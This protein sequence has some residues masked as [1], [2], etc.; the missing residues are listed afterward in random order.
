MCAV[1]CDGIEECVSYPGYDE[2]ETNGCEDSCIK[3]FRA[4]P[5]KQTIQSPL[6]PENYAN[7]LDCEYDI[8]AFDGEVIEI[9]IETFHIENSGGCIYDVFA[10]QDGSKSP[11]QYLEVGGRKKVCGKVANDTIIESSESSVKI[12]FQT[13]FTVTKP[14]WSLTFKSK[15][16]TVQSRSKRSS[17]NSNASKSSLFDH[18][19]FDDYYYFYD[20]Y[21]SDELDQFD[22][23]TKYNWFGVYRKS[24]MPDYSDFRNF[25]SFKQTELIGNGH[26]KSDFIVQCVFDG[27]ICSP[28]EFSTIQT[29]T[30][31][32]CFTFN[33]V[34]NPEKNFTNHMRPLRTAKV[35]S[36]HGLKL[37]FFLDKEEYIGIIG[38]NSGARVTLF[39]SKEA[40]PVET[41]G[42]SLSAGTATI[43]ALK[44]ETIERKSDP[45]SSCATT[46]PDF[47]ELCDNYKK[48]QYTQDYC[49]HLCIMKSMISKCGCSDS[50][51]WDFSCNDKIKRLAATHCDV[52]NKTQSSCVLQ[53]YTDFTTR[54]LQCDCPA[55]CYERRLNVKQSFTQWPTEAYAPYFASLMFR[56]TSTRVQSF[57][58]DEI[59]E[60]RKEP[61]ELA[62]HIQNNFAR[63]EI[64]FEE[65]KFTSIK[66]TPKYNISTLFGTLGGNL[67]LWLGWSI[68][69]LFE[70][71]EWI[72]KLC[73]IAMIRTSNK[74][75]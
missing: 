53:I 72:Y 56:S 30:Y 32:N 71:L 64:H 49:N 45:F 68:L 74:T 25:L 16:K 24:T 60:H 65:L 10:I 4:S 31:G 58:A 44:Q 70:F 73:I 69:S 12:V 2:T 75:T 62:S 6:Y 63:L 42:L 27:N 38:Q 41:S 11:V 23:V 51:D 1:P 19:L 18:N 21:G 22:N 33:A 29:P 34:V 59:I 35:G 52:W 9:T 36:Q 47:L 17:G 43:L 39:N 13:D 5:E 3:S 28:S 40:P 20:D 67:G 61:E 54:K 57:V 15:P 55:P 46:W 50:F 14:G 48:Y 37:S 26:Q 8:T 66:E 7:Y